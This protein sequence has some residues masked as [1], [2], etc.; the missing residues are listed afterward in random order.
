MRAPGLNAENR[1]QAVA[2][3][4]RDGLLAEDSLSPA[5]ERARA[6]TA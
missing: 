3:A 2:R 1:V 4:T 5:D 6:L